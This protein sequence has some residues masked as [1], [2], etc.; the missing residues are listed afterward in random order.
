LTEELF[1][2]VALSATAIAFKILLG[3][4]TMMVR[5]LDNTSVNKFGHASNK[6]VLFSNCWVADA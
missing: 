3:D 5:L 2:N 1:G 6:L 4:D